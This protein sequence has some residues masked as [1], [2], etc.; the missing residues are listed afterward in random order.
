MDVTLKVSGWGGVGDVLTFLTG[1]SYVV[2]VT[3]KVSGWGGVG[4]VLTFLTG[5]VLRCGCY[6]EGLGL[7]WGGGCINVL[8]R[9]RLTLWMLR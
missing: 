3:L 1:V 5:V 7:G 8:D 2:D 6:V 9:S 4:D